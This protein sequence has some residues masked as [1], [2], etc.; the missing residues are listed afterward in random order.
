M[1]KLFI[2]SFAFCGLATFNIKAQSTNLIDLVAKRERFQFQIKSLNDSLSVIDRKIASVNSTLEFSQMPNV[3]IEAVISKRGKIKD[4][5]SPL[6]N[7]IKVFADEKKIIIL[8]YVD[9]YFK[10]CDGDVCGFASTLWIVN[11]PEIE[12]YVDNKKA[13]DNAIRIA[14]A[15]RISQQQELQVKKKEEYL[16]KK[17][18]LKTYNSLKD[19]YYWLGMTKEMALI[20]FGNPTDV[21]E[22]VGSWGTREQWVYNNIYLYFENGILASYQR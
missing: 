16:V 21:N 6:A 13:V 10:V 18:G 1:K 9:E 3:K 2:L 12:Q 5:P 4:A 19:G 17:L 14:N 11:S 7:E 22:T 20:A 8:D 15:K